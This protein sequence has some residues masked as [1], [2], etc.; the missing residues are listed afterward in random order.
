M[1]VQSANPPTKYLTFGPWIY[2][3]PQY[4]PKNIL[5]LGYAGSTVAGLIRLLYG[6]IPITGV[7]IKPCKNLYNVEFIQAD[8]KEFVKDCKHF[9][10]VIVDVCD[11]KNICDFVTS[12][13]F[14]NDLAKIANYIIINTFQDKDMSAY[15]H[16]KLAGINK[17][18]RLA[19]KIYYYQTTKIPNLHIFKKGA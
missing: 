17:P 13:G 3:V 8:A 1:L 12:K 7:D 2:L 14:A 9:D 4:K 15:S 5:I 18:S 19:N 6:D 10:C 11:E 16:L